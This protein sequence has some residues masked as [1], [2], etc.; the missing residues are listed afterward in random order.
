MWDHGSPIALGSLGGKTAAAGASVNNR[1][2]VVGGSFLADETTFHSYLWTKESGMIDTGAVDS[3]MSA[4]PAQIND[5]GQ[6][7]GCSCD[8]D[9]SGNCRAYIWQYM[10]SDASA[11]SAMTDLNTL[12]SGDTGLYLLFAFGI[13]NAGEIVGMAI[14]QDSGAPHA[15]LATPVNGTAS[16]AAKLQPWHISEKARKGMRPRVR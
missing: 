5:S 10:G 16:A 8:T 3:D 11:S 2:E 14:D 12:I 9:Q 4:Y 15:F 7:V 1:S 6:V 13:N